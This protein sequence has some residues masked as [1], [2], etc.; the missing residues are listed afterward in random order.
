[1][2]TSQWVMLGCVWLATLGGCGL[3]RRYA[4]H[5]ALLDHPGERSSH[6][7]PTP[8]GGGLAVAAALLAAVGYMAAVRWLDW[9]PA[10]ALLGGGAAVALVGWIDDHGHVPALWRAT[11]HAAAAVWAVAWLGGMP[12][13]DLGV[14]D[15][16]PGIF[17]SVLGAVALVWLTNLYNFMDGIDTLAAG[18]AIFAGLAGGTM[19]WLQGAQGL[20]L[21]GFAL[22]AAGG[23]FL[24]WNRPPAKLFLGDSGSGLMGFWVGF[25]ALASETTG[26]LPALVWCILL[27]VFVWDAT[28]TLADRVMRGER[29]YTAH[30]EHAYQRL[31]ALG[32]SHGRVSLW[33]MIL[34]LSVFLPLAW[35]GWRHPRWL[36]LALIVSVVVAAAVWKAVPRAPS[37]PRADNEPPGTDH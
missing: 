23:G 34:N 33:A 10:G 6:S 3:V 35:I 24:V 5:K 14:L 18:E 36:L 16:T 11:V 13:L 1:M 27:S 29:W 7:V 19:L 2:S 22:A 31:V 37:P 12:F 4:L 21:A 32:S 26:A 8:R 30:R 9:R 25:L 15:L 28:L 17:G 20:A